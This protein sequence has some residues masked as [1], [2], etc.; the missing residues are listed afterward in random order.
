MATMIRNEDL[1]L[2]KIKSALSWNITLPELCFG[3]DGYDDKE[4]QTLI[5]LLR[6]LFRASDLLGPSSEPLALTRNEDLQWDPVAQPS[7][8]GSSQRKSQR[9]L[10]IT[11]QS[12]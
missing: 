1:C 2:T 10:R 5:G 3:L 7:A 8:P 11:L 4:R 9:R 12:P 6:T